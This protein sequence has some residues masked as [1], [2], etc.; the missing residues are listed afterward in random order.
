[1]REH[2]DGKRLSDMSDDVPDEA[3]PAP[4]RRKLTHTV[5][6][7]RYHVGGVVVGDS[8]VVAAARQ[9]LARIQRDHRLRRRGD[10]QPSQTPELNELIRGQDV[11]DDDTEDN[12]EEGDGDA[13]NTDLRPNYTGGEELT[14]EH[15]KRG[16]PRKH[17]QGVT[18]SK[19][20]CDISEREFASGLSYVAVSRVSRLEGLM[21]DVSFDRS[22]VNHDPPTKA[23]QAKLADYEHRRKNR[24]L[25]PLYRPAN[26]MA[27]DTESSP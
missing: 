6:S 27:S 21:F 20:V 22:R 23:M 25:E 15:R 14:V 26:D 4:K 2:V 5:M 13:G 18:L 9:E 3:P 16:R 17:P 7:E 10:E 19:V 12:G 1:M 11:D 24:L 8:T